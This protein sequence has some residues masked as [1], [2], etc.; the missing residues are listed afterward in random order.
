MQQLPR[1]VPRLFRTGA[2]E[3]GG[4]CEDYEQRERG[5][6]REETRRYWSTGASEELRDLYSWPGL[7]SAGKVEATRTLEGETTV[8]QRF[9]LTS[10]DADAQAFARAVRNHWGMENRL[11]RTL[12]VTFHEDQSRLRKGHGP[13]NFAVL[14]HMA[15]N[16]LR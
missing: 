9:Y 4:S 16:L 2:E 12:A 8:E 6:G 10:L 13:E 1:A 7:R 11:Q 15:L 14:R 3:R 5:H